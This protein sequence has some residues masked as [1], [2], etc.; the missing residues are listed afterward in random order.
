MV[1]VRKAASDESPRELVFPEWLGEIRVRTREAE[2]VEVRLASQFDDSPA[3]YEGYVVVGGRLRPL[4]VGST[5]DVK[6]GAFSWQPGPGFV[7]SYD[8]VFLR[9]SDAG[10]KTRIPVE[11][12]IRPKHDGDDR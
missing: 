10:L 9:T 4:P 3:K 1:E 12:R 6:T 5:L 2:L 7:G 11:I 8:F